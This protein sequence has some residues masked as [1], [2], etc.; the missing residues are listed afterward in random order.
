[1][2]KYASLNDREAMQLGRTALRES[3]EN[4]FVTFPIDAIKE[5]EA[6]RCKGKN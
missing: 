2:L 6:K 4:G 5:V 3:L 1:M